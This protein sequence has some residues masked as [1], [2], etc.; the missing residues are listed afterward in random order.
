VRGP[1]IDRPRIA[2]LSPWFDPLGNT[3]VASDGE[4]HGI[5]LSRIDALAAPLDQLLALAERIPAT[6]W[7]SAA[8]LRGV[9]V[10]TRVGEDLLGQ[11]DRDRLWETFQAPVF[12][13]LR[14]PGGDLLASECEAQ[15]GLHIDVNNATFAA[16]PD[17]GQL[18]VA[19]AS[20]GLT[21]PPLHPIG[22]AGVVTHESCECHST[23]PRLIA[24]RSLVAVP[25]ALAISA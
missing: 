22:F 23:A 15:N 4:L 6:R 11:P 9:L 2:V 3:C 7:R 12:E 10:L 21:P 5:D 25:Q 19:I 18:R 13:E 24:A 1:W 17:T 8:E 20:E 16:C 14:G